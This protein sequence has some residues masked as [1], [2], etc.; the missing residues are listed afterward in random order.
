MSRLNPQKNSGGV[1]DEHNLRDG[2]EAGREKETRNLEVRVR[3]VEPRFAA[4]TLVFPG[5]F[6]AA[7]HRARHPIEIPVDGMHYNDFSNWLPDSCFG[8]DYPPYTRME[9]LDPWM[10]GWTQED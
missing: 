1:N 5:K 3:G 9:Y 7:V 8:L 6:R 4:S 10:N 2:E